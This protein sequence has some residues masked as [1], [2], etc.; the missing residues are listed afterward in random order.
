MGVEQVTVQTN[1]CSNNFCLNRLSGNDN[2][3]TNNCRDGSACINEAFGGDRN[4][5]TNNCVVGDPCINRADQETIILKILIARVA[6]ASVLTI[7]WLAITMFRI[8]NVMLLS[9]VPVRIQL[10][11]TIMLRK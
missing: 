3:Q 1:N 7:Q 5:Q 11:V 2:I 4:T 9:L 6:E 10:V 8:W